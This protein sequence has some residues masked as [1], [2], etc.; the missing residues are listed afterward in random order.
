MHN[1]SDKHSTILPNTKVV[2][3]ETEEHTIWRIFGKTYQ[4][5][6]IISFFLKWAGTALLLYHYSKKIG[7]KRYWFLLC[8]PVAYFSTLLIYH[9]HIY[10]PQPNMES[11]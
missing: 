5:S 10:E 8:L 9:F 7:R 1:F 11:L 6:D 2:F 3:P 4:D